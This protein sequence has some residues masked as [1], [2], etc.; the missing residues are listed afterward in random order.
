MGRGKTIV[1]ELKEAIVKLVTVGHLKHK[2][3][4]D[5]L[6]IPRSTIANIVGKFKR[7]G[8]TK[9]TKSTG[10]PSK[11]SPADKRSLVKLTK[12]SRFETFNE[13]AAR[14]N[15]AN[16]CRLSETTVRA[17]FKSLGHRSYKASNDHSN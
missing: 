11:L 14:W 12:R 2:F 3:L 6:D 8:S 1:P 15:A 16:I 10:R 13:V 5:T 17:T 9:G 4:A 7:T